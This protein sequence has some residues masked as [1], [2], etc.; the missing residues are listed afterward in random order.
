VVIPAS[1]AVELKMIAID[2]KMI[3]ARMTDLS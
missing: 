3:K 1:Q 2:D